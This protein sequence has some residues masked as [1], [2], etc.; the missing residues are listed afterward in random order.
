MGQ[1]PSAHPDPPATLLTPGSASRGGCLP[2]TAPT[3]LLVESGHREAQAGGQRA[4]GTSSQAAFPWL[5]R[6]WEQ[7]VVRPEAT[8]PVRW[9]SPSCSEAPQVLGTSLF[10]SLQA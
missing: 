3:C 4:G 1:S 9:P 8:A 7:T 5:F 6:C 10:S 2:V